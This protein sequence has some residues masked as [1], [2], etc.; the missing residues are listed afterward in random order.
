MI[1]RKSK[2]VTDGFQLMM[3]EQGGYATPNLHSKMKKIPVKGGNKY[4]EYAETTVRWNQKP[5]KKIDLKAQKQ[6]IDINSEDEYFA[7]SK[8]FTTHTQH[9]D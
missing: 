4:R 3:K 9:T 6:T 8:Q 2:E 1:Q 7:Q 5:N